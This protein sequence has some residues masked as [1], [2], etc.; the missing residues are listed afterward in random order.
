MLQPQ[1]ID[2]CLETLKG[3]YQLPEHLKLQKIGEFIKSTFSITPDIYSPKNLKYLFSYPDPVGI[4][5]DFISN[6]IHSNVHTEE[7]SP[8]FTRCEIDVINTLTTLVNYP[9][10]DGVFYPGGSLSNLA[11]VVLAKKTAQVDLSNA[12]ALISDHAH[13]SIPEAI[14]IC[15]IPHILNVKT[16][17]SGIADLT[18]LE[19]QV[20]YIRQQKKHLIYFCCVMGTTNF[21][22]FD[23]AAEI[24]TIFQA[25]AQ[26]PWI[27]FDAAWGGG[28][29]FSQQSDDYKKLSAYSDSITLDFHKFLSAPLLCSTLLVKDKTVLLKNDIAENASYLFNDKQD[30]TYSLSLKSL[31][32]SREAYAFKLWLMIRYH[33]IQH[34]R[35]LIQHYEKY[36]NIFEQQF[37]DRILF[38]V[39][40]HYF[41]LCFWFIPKDLSV[42]KNILDYTNEEKKNIGSLNLAIYEKIAK[43][44]TIKINYANFNK[45][46]V[47]IR[48]I[49]HHDNL[50]KA[51]IS[52]IVRY[53]YTQY[54]TIDPCIDDKYS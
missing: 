54:E 12:V 16:T 22:T 48:I 33:G 41:N 30:T 24:Y 37:T 26:K 18:H 29:Y 19:E 17:S 36:R 21:G 8:I 46:P 4:F 28:V 27:H 25:Q 2:K 13:Y 7:C 23:P 43:E 38:V 9:T 53:L 5:A 45:L 15:G 32:C 10:G 42:K 44:D 6:T 51:I 40:P 49:V 20:T 34:F 3:V 31:Q 11:S 52:G 39:Q 14:K 1:E 47:F 35:N 50:N